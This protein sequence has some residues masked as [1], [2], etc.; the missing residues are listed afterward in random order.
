MTDMLR[1]PESKRIVITIARLDDD[2]K[3]LVAHARDSEIGSV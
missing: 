2:P 3:G 1:T